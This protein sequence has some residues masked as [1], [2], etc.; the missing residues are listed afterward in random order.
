M[1]CDSGSLALLENVLQYRISVAVQWNDFKLFFAL[2]FSFQY[3]KILLGK[4][5]Q[6]RKLLE[7]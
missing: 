4:L 6:P 2:S 7:F 3:I 5:L 1:F